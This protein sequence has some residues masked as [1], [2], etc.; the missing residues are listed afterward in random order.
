MSAL[1]SPFNVRVANVS[2]AE[3]IIPRNMRLGYSVLAP[4]VSAMPIIFEGDEVNPG[5]QELKRSDADGGRA[6]NESLKA[7]EKTGLT[8][9]DVNLSQLTKERRKIVL[10]MLEP[11]SS[12]WQGQL[13]D[14][15]A[16][17][18]RIELLP[19]AR[20]SFAQPYRAGP[21][22]G[23]IIQG[24]I[25]DLQSKGRIEPAKSKWAAPVVLAPKHDGTVRFCVDYLRLNAVT[26]R[27]SCPLPRMVDCLDSLSTAQFSTTL[28]CNSGYWQVPIAAEDRHKT[29]FTS[30]AGTFQWK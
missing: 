25:E 8:I 18:H 3:E 16:T 24:H 28:D 30:H 10:E 6:A 9:E 7:A 2:D 17:E 27:D 11:F 20:P 22:S 5:S 15:K 23:K 14:A 1:M 29:A 13:G 26:V 21:D 12:L 4:Y 19:G